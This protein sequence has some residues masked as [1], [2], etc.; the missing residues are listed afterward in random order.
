MASPFLHYIKEFMFTRHYAKRTI[1]TYLYWIKFYIIFNGKQHPSDLGDR[2]VENFLSYLAN[3]KSLAVKSQ[4]T[5]LNAIHFLYKHII[6]KPISLNLQFSKSRKQQ[7]LPTVLTRQEIT[8]L[9]HSLD[10]EYSLPIKLMY[11]SGLRVSE[12]LKLR[13]QDIDFDY[14]SILVWYSK[15]GKH[16]RTTLAAELIPELRSQICTVTGYFKKDIANPSFS[17]VWMPFSLSKKYPAAPKQLGW[18][19]LFPSK[20]LSSDPADGKIRRHHLN[21][22][23]LRRVIKR[24]GNEAGINKTISCHTLRHSFATHLLESGVDI[25]TVQEQLGHSDIRTTQIYTHVLNQGA[26]GVISPLSKLS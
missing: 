5:A 2:D 20:T 4:K 3:Q 8:L 24:A 13:V 14:L 16:R 17:G 22:T 26:N 12:L 7:K 25:R 11:G 9:I 6:K 10:P 1:D 19:F 23:T 21:E 18:Q 15:G